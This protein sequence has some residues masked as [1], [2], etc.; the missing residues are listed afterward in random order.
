MEFLDF[1]FEHV[2]CSSLIHVHH[3]RERNNFIFNG[4]ELSIIELKSTYFRSLFEW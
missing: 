1:L 4:V 3:M 2:E